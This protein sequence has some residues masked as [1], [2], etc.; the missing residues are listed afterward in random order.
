MRS[1]EMEAATE[2][3]SADDCVP[4]CGGE[5]EAARAVGAPESA[6]ER[7]GGSG[8]PLD[9][10]RRRFLASAAAL[11]VTFAAGLGS[12][13]ALWSARPAPAG[14]SQTLAASAPTS[15]PHTAPALPLRYALP[16]SYGSIG[17]HLIRAG[18]FA[19]DAFAAVFEGSATPLTKEQ[20]R[21]LQEGSGEQ[22][23]I[24]EQNARFLLNL[25][26]A[27]GLANN[28]P[29]LRTGT[30]VAK[31][32][33]DGFASTGGWTLATAPV[34]MLYAASSLATL[35][36]RQ[37]ARLEEAV[38]AIYRPCCDNAT[39][40]P[41]CNHGMAM[42]GLLEVLAARGVEVEEL[43]DAAKMVNRFWFPS[44]SAEL[45]LYYRA[46]GV[47]EFAA[48]SPR[49]A[50]SAERFS[51]RGFGEMHKWLVGNGLLNSQNQGGSNCGV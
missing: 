21:I 12:G 34:H 14:A 11:S 8:A 46:Q 38:D 2:A 51:G 32:S 40:F 25:F 20:R 29:I 24:D 48:I 9:H 4:A 7:V 42:L 37:Q 31:G 22:I 3:E 39:S 45:A 30:M 44:Q 6:E 43:F 10:S 19:F 17:P 33:V 5:A 15:V 28:N 36:K 49:E 50:V 26:W 16:L 47:A 41:D 18:V 23:V 1:P 35:D 13:F 27:V